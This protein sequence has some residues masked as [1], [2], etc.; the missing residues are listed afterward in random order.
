[1][2][3]ALHDYPESTIIPPRSAHTHSIILLHGRGDCGED[4]GAE[5]VST[6][7]YSASSFKTLPQRFPGAKFIFPTARLRKSEMF[8]PEPLSQWFDLTCLTPPSERKDLQHDGLRESTKVVHGI[9]NAEAAAVGV[10][11]V[12]VGGLSQGAAQALHVLL[13]Y[14]DGG[15]GSLGGYVGMSGWL[16]FHEELMG[17]VSSWPGNKLRAGDDGDSS[18]T[19]AGSHIPLNLR[20][21]AVN[22]TRQSILR[23]PPLKP[24]QY[25]GSL[26]TPIWLGHGAIDWTVKLEYGQQAATTM[27]KLGW[28]VTWKAYDDLEHWFAPYELEDIATFLRDRVGVPEAT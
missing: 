8:E 18:V 6:E 5:L 16:P 15:K 9:I 13:S 12:I 20:V 28:D 4:F 17:L 3:T 10:G 23:M 24:D 26:K 2:D 27:E 22:F 1:M 11:N 14:D 7:L 21:Q 25:P 19:D